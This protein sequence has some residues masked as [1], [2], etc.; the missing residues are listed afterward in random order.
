MSSSMQAPFS[1]LMLTSG[2]PNWPSLRQSLSAFVSVSA[3][4]QHMSI[5]YAFITMHSPHAKWQGSWCGMGDGQGVA[6]E[7]Q[8]IISFQAMTA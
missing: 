3:G 1:A 5:K 4:T 6:W 2:T 7:G 8:I